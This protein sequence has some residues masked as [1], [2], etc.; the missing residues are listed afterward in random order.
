MV[1]SLMLCV[2]VSVVAYCL[3]PLEEPTSTGDPQSNLQS[4][5]NNVDQDCVCLVAHVCA[6]LPS[7][8]QKFLPLF[9][10]VF[11]LFCLSQQNT[12]PRFRVCV[13]LD[14]GNNNSEKNNDFGCGSLY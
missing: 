11:F 7:I 3:S 14:K 2:C 12:S 5:I 4:P 6:I 9:F 8:L 10:L 1:L 13:C